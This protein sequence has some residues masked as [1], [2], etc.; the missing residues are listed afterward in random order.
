MNRLI[1][2]LYSI[3]VS[4]A[5]AGSGLILC[6][7]I[8]IPLLGF[9]AG[10]VAAVGTWNLAL[11]LLAGCLLLI[12]AT[13]NRAKIGAWDFGHQAWFPMMPLV[14]VSLISLVI[15]GFMFFLDR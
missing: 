9:A 1:R 15:I 13:V 11:A 5:V 7:F 6:G 3:T 12:A 14:V 2:A 8:S 4:C 10:T